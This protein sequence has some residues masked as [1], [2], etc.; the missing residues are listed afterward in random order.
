MNRSSRSNSRPPACKPAA[1]K[2]GKD[3]VLGGY[4]FDPWDIPFLPFAGRSGL[5]VIT[6]GHSNDKRKRACPNQDGVNPYRSG[7]KSR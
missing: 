2:V 6:D 5:V 7:A 4:A 3:A 1:M